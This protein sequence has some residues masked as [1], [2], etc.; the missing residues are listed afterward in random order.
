MGLQWKRRP[1]RQA[2]GLTRL[3]RDGAD[4]EG[5][6]TQTGTH[7]GPVNGNEWIRDNVGSVIGDSRIS[8]QYDTIDGTRY[9]Y[10]RLIDLRLSCPDCPAMCWRP[11]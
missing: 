3:M 8:G 7:D 11:F 10:L 4:T 2:L 9:G 5:E 1:G 6:H